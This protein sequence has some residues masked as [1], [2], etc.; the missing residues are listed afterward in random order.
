MK[1]QETITIHKAFAWALAQ[2]FGELHVIDNNRNERTLGASRFVRGLTSTEMTAAQNTLSVYKAAAND[3]YNAD[4]SPNIGL[5]E[6]VQEVIGE[7]LSADQIVFT[8]KR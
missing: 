1:Q 8:I 4:R 7:P 2:E 5:P 3:H 6:I